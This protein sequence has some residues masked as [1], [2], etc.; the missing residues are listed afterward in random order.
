MSVLLN[1]NI[2][3]MNSY[4]ENIELRLALHYSL[5]AAQ[6]NPPIFCYF[7]RKKRLNLNEQGT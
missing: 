1:G 2:D 5:Y 7:I 6:H 4:G 3:L